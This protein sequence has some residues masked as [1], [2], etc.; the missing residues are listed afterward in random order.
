MSDE[1]RIFPYGITLKEGG[2]VD[3]FPAVEIR[4]P[5][6]GEEFLSLFFLIDSGAHISAMPARDAEMFDIRPAD[7]DVLFISGVGGMPVRGWKHILPVLF[8]HK[9]VRV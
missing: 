3:V 6:R 2:V 1:S 9:T 8:A 4:F 5:L 7:G